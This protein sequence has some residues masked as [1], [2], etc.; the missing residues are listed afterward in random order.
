MWRGEVSAFM[1]LRPILALISLQS[2]DR[3]PMPAVSDKEKAALNQM[4]EKYADV[5]AW[6]KKT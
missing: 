4:I 1:L 3:F 2:R 6:T 5:L